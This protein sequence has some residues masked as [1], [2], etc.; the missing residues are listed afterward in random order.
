LQIRPFCLTAAKQ[1]T[2][3]TFVIMKNKYYGASIAILEHH[4]C[5][6]GIQIHLLLWNANPRLFTI[7]A[8]MYCCI[9]VN[10]AQFNVDTVVIDIFIIYFRIRK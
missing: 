3:A 10:N 2:N 6:L 1:T 5:Y 7:Y 4:T 8:D 9:C